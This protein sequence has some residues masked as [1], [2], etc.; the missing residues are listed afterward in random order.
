MNG[1]LGRLEEESVVAY[2][3]ALSRLSREV[4]KPRKTVLPSA[5]V[6]TRTLYLP[7]TSRL[8]ADPKTMDT[9]YR[10]FV[11]DNASATLRKGTC[12]N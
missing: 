7:N 5:P 11:C 1:E 4:T 6:Q 3:N 8:L 2:L 10:C 12:P 9:D